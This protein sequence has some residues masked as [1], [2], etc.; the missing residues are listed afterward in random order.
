[1]ASTSM[2]MNQQY[3]LNKVPLNTNMHKTR[4][5]IDCLVKIM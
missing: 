1:L 5:Y 2:L 3:I 4:L